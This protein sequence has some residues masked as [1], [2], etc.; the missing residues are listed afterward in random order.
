MDGKFSGWRM[1]D[2]GRSLVER[3]QGGSWK[4]TALKLGVSVTEKDTGN[5]RFQDI[6]RNTWGVGGNVN[7]ES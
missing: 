1:M 4:R 5:C 6:S 3:S 7:M 2:G